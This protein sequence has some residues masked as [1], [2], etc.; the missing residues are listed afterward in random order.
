[1]VYA[2]FQNS[3]TLSLQNGNQYYLFLRSNV[4]ATGDDKFTFARRSEV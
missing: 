1:M 4:A 2:N 3:E